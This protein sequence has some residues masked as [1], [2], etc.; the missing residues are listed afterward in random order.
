M[1]KPVMLVGDPSGTHK[2]SLY[3]ETC[4]DLLKNKGFN[5]LPAST[6]DIEARLRAVESFLI[7][8]S[9]GGPQLIVDR[10]RC[11]TLVRGFSGGYRFAHTR[12]GQQKP[13]PDKE[14]GDYSHVHDDLQYV[15][16]T[17]HGGVIP[18]HMQYR[19]RPQ[20]AGKQVRV[21]AAG[22]T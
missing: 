6:N 18:L 17:V 14:N 21:S 13:T 1:G 15:C 20:R 7:G 5:A 12:K 8:A 9:D 4:F 2:D 10:E 3:E 19:L 22:W 11:P 16:L